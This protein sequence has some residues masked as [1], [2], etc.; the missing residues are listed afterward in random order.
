MDYVIATDSTCD[1]P[2]QMLRSMQ[3]YSRD[4]TYYVNDVAYGK[5][6]ANQ[7]EFHQFYDAIRAGARNG[8]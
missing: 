2:K 3:V 8:T 1:I 7:L 6:E 4:M 5:D